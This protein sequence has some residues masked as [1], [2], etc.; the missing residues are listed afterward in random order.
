MLARDSYR[1]R[2]VLDELERL[3]GPRDRFVDMGA[4]L[5]VVEQDP[6]GH[7][8]IPGRPPLRILR[9]H[10]FGGVVDTKATPPALVGPSHSPVVWY[11]GTEQERIILHGDDL[12]LRVLVW[13]AEGAGKTEVLALWLLLRALG[14]TG[15]GVSIGATAPTEPR[16]EM[17]ESAIRSKM[18]ADWYTWSERKK[19]FQL[20]NG[21]EIQLLGTHRHSAQVGEK[22]QGYNWAACASDEIQDTS[23]EAE[24][25]I[26]MR[27]RTAPDGRYRRLCTSSV[28]DS[29]VWRNRRT[30]KEKTGA[31]ASLRLD[32]FSNPFVPRRF[33]EEKKQVLSPRA[34][35]RRVLALDVGPERAV[36]TSWDRRENVR[37]VPRVGARDVT[38][39]VLRQVTGQANQH[40]LLGHDP[41]KLWDVTVGLKA[42]ELP[43]IPDYV[44]WAVFECTT[45]QSTTQQHVR[46]LQERLRKEWSLCLPPIRGDRYSIASDA[47]TVHVRCD[48]YGDAETQT[49]RSVYHQFRAHGFDIKSAAYKNGKSA[50]KVPREPGIEVVNRLLCDAS[51]RRRL[52]VDCDDRG[53]PVC[54]K[55]V[56]ALEES[57]RDELGRAETQRKDVKDLSHW[58]AALRYALWRFE[59][60][61]P[62]GPAWR[63]A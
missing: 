35:R 31:W 49:H 24:D 4:V 14:F 29:T 9:S 55:L 42:Y 10:R 28:K 21:I 59:K 11:C 19:R 52:F 32:G 40:M 1:A 23:A 22:T 54:P 12:P 53:Q 57:E 13:G 34:Y 45:P 63:T 38:R 61:V 41:G 60:V 56:E 62:T 37:P 8:I 15:L 5:H 50:G 16:L 2:R 48:P 17:V 51:G 44:W 7:E 25:G 6:D 26:E 46:T 27:G 43:G 58:P 39:H 33:W 36:Y 30:A 3:A 18:P 47:D 20:A